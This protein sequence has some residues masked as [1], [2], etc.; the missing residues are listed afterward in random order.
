MERLK[1]FIVKHFEKVL[2]VIILIA[3][4]AGTYFVEDKSIVLN[5]YYLPVLSAGYFLGRRLGVLTALF[6]IVVVVLSG[7]L[8]PETL[9][10]G[11]ESI[12]P[13]PQLLSWSG[14]LILSTIAVGTLYEQN[15]RRLQDLKNAYI[16]VLEILSKYL[17]S[18]D[19]YTKGH[20]LRVSE[21]A[22]EIAIGMEL[23][24]SDVEN[25]RVAGLL[26][27]IGKIEVSGEILLKAAS[28]SSEEQGLVDAHSAKGAYLLSSV[29]SVLREVVPIVMSHHEYFMSGYEHN[30]TGN[31][32][33]PLGSRVIA[34]ADAF[35]AMTSDRPY[36][37]GM[38]PWEAL[39]EIAKNTGKQFDPD[40]VKVFKLVI[41]EKV[42]NV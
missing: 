27:D 10:K 21:M 7:L 4:F 8:F 1:E 25:I 20:S 9:L 2:V 38:P 22:R 6:S 14:F 12:S 36:R 33:I 28:L 13:L 34:V 37:K 31:N 17:E 18:T 42:E 23:P 15:Q 11:K 30:K 40:V 16:G 3:T 41:G 5:F 32:H 19:R 26:H 24:R 39:E 35:D 29:G